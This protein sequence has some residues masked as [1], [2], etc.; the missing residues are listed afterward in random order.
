MPDP[1]QAPLTPDAPPPVTVSLSHVPV[2]VPASLSGSP[3]FWST[4]SGGAVAAVCLLTSARDLPQGPAQ[5]RLH[6]IEVPV[7]NE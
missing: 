6:H 2:D 4:C 3:R 7:E 5:M 1:S